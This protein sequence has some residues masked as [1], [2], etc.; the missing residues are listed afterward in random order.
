MSLINRVTATLREDELTRRVL[1]S[2]GVLLSSN[3]IALALS[4][5]QSILAARLLGAAGFGLLAIVMGYAST[6]N[7]LLSFRMSEAVVRYGGEFLQKGEDRRAAALL[8]AAG[9]TEAVVSAL[10]FLV[11]ALT[12]TLAARY[13][14]KDAGSAALFPLL[15]IGLLCNFST[16]TGTGVLQALGRIRFQ[17]VIHL[18][19]AAVTSA[20]MLLVYI[21]NGD[22]L[23]V[24]G[25]YLV[26]KAITGLG[27]SVYAAV[28]AT[29]RLGRGWWT[30]PLAELPRLRELARFALS[31]N[32][33]ATAILV[34]RESEVLWVGFFLT[35]EAA[36]LY[37]AAYGII[38][39]LS[40]P[41]NP[42]ILSTYP[43]INDIVVQRAWAR[44]RGFLRRITS[45]A[46]VYNVVLAAVFV[47]LG[48][49][50]LRIYGPEYVAGYAALLALLVGLVF[51]YV[52]FWNRPLLLALG[53][54]SFPLKVITTAG[55]VKTAL[56]FL[57]VP[58]FGIV[59]AAALLS[60]YYVASVGTMA[61]RGWSEIRRR[62]AV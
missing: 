31:S 58:T 16:E 44:L 27:T 28:L 9:L 12:S 30:T 11:V 53:L 20:L 24:L 33:S 57:L 34:F 56:A 4:V 1:A 19:Q 14:A 60:F 38:S 50:L 49:W 52:L 7:G 25:V 22:L 23:L 46:F 47:I 10:A 54:P 62:E 5:L 45:L 3:S 18:V 51:N 6:V 61:W 2:S 43:E 8:K 37:K 21:L 40:V 35:S 42:L 48:R 17:G 59:A 39:L 55:L 36:G 32:L 29:R 26:G 15:A 13:I 41:A